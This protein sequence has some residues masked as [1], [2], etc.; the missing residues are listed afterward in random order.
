LWKFKFKADYEESVGVVYRIPCSAMST[1]LYIL[2]LCS[3]HRTKG[4]A[5]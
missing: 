3:L 2:V 1:M 4:W 5:S